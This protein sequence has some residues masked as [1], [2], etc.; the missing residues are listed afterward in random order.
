[1]GT[2]LL[3]AARDQHRRPP[4]ERLGGLGLGHIGEKQTLQRHVSKPS[5]RSVFLDL[6]KR[7]FRG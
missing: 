2:M 7:L 3:D 4:T 6:R 1:M 5:W